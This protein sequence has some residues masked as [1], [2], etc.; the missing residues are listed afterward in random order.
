MT[1]FGYLSIALGGAM[2]ALLR[3]IISTIVQ[4]Q[5]GDPFPWGT[6]TVNVSGSL[7]IGILFQMFDQ[8][9]VS[10]NMKRLLITGGL[11]AF[12]TFSTYSLETFQL[13]QNRNFGLALINLGGSTLAGLIA[14][15]LGISIVRFLFNLGS[16]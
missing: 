3:H 1:L 4:T 12:T 16:S 8:I 13:I 5:I 7:L 14:V 9:A 6:L 15:F 2:G 10:P 11:G